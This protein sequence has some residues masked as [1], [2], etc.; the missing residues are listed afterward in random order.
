MHALSPWFYS[1]VIATAI[2]LLFLFLIKWLNFF[3]THRPR[4]VFIALAWGAIAVELS[5]LVDHPLVPIFGRPFVGTHTAP[6][7]EEILKSLVLLF[8]VRRADHTHFVDS[9][10]YGFAAGIGFAVAENMLYLSRFDADTGR[11]IA[12]LRAFSSAMMHGGTTALVGIAIGGF[13]FT[14]ALNPWLAWVLGLVVAIACH[15]TYNNIA[16]RTSGAAGS[17]TLFAVAFAIMMLVAAAILWGLHRE[18]RR[19]RVSLGMKSGVSKGEAKL[20]QRI[21][22]L[23]DLLAPVESH[24][25]ERKREQVANV[26]LLAAQ[27]GMK[28]D[29]IRKTKD[30]ELRAELAEQLTDMKRA[31]KRERRAVGMYVMSYVRAIVPKTDWSLWARVAQ[32]IMKRQA[33]REDMWHS[34]ARALESGKDPGADLHA[35]IRNAL[36]ARAARETG[37]EADPEPSPTFRPWAME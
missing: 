12:I 13:P 24:F 15:M 4:L 19:L 32:A 8:L 18:R 6:V 31:L 7:V 5:Y 22:D 21:D 17:F 26:L 34:L 29:L 11:I 16:F 25:G 1:S 35:S 20:I 14:R 27:L 23:D 30:P 33:P 10:I 2:P 37:H 9:A 3:E 36:Q 28:Q